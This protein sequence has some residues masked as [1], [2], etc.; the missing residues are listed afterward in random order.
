[1]EGTKL[2]TCR[3]SRSHTDEYQ[4]ESENRI[5]SIC[6]KQTHKNRWGYLQLHMLVSNVHCR[7]RKHLSTTPHNC[8][9]CAIARLRVLLCLFGQQNVSDAGLVFCDQ[10]YKTN[11][12]SC[13]SVRCCCC[14][15]SNKSTNKHSPLG[16]ATFFGHQQLILLSRETIPISHL[17]KSSTNGIVIHC[18]VM[19]VFHCLCV[20]TY[21]VL[22]ALCCE[23]IALLVFHIL[24]QI[25]E[26]IKENRSRFTTF[27]IAERHEASPFRFH[28]VQHLAETILEWQRFDADRFHPVL[29][30][31][32][33]IFQL[34]H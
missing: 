31:L 12:H 25:E 33:E 4:Y 17:V 20:C 3:H 28:H 21:L 8:A 34:V 24:F 13:S 14:C 9:D 7:T 18:I 26:R 19:P 32:V 1:M 10:T 6:S 5:E 15:C 30:L 16:V 23:W 22:V 29:L 11:T 27:Q 2:N